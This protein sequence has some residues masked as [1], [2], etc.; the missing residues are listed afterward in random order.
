MGVMCS[1]KKQFSCINIIFILSGFVAFWAVITDAWGYSDRIFGNSFRNTGTYLYGY[2]SRCIW[3]IP[4]ILLIIKYNNQ[5]KIPKCEL[6]KPLKFDGSLI[7]VIAISLGY[8]VTGMFINHK[9]FW[10]NSQN[11][12]GLVVV[13]YIV[14]GLVE[15]TV[16]RG[17]GYNSLSKIVPHKKAAVISTVFF[18]LLHWPAY[19]IKLYKFGTFDFMGLIGQ[20]SSALIWG[21][22]LCWLLNKS[23]TLWNSIL[24]HTIYD[25]TYILLIGG[26]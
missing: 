18:V 21:F 11:T 10:F 2:F 5:L 4:A 14:V 26:N 16:F 17:W 3:A 24:A 6:Y 8:V 15:E 23:K 13:K 9:G 7:I 22:V 19:F 20:S 25:L 12:L 1:G